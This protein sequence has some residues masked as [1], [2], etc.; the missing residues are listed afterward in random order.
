VN[1]FTKSGWIPVIVDIITLGNASYNS[2]AARRLLDDSP[3][4]KKF[5]RIT[6]NTLP[7]CYLDDFSSLSKI[8][9]A[10]ETWD[11]SE[12]VSFLLP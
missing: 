12:A 6:P 7:Q 8:R 5:L 11:H 4:N 3:D 1:V 2:Y 10:W 9:E